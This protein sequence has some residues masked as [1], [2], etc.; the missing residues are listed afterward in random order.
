[1]IVF[2]FE[3]LTTKVD[4]FRNLHI[5]QKLSAKNILI[6]AVYVNS[7]SLEKKYRKKNIYMVTLKSN[8]FRTQVI[9]AHKLCAGT[10]KEISN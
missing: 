9:T 1:M 7:A 6:G 10:H 5:Q 2:L 3:K 4:S 8:Y